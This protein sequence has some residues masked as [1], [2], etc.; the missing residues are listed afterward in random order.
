MVRVL[1]S[2]SQSKTSD[3]DS[4]IQLKSVGFYALTQNTDSAKFPKKALN[5]DCFRYSNS[6]SVTTLLIS[7]VKVPI[8]TFSLDEENSSK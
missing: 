8:E 3:L 7:S 4:N 2:K 5:I 6:F 1:P